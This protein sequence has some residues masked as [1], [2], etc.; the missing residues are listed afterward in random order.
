MP[1]IGDILKKIWCF[2]AL[3]GCIEAFGQPVSAADDKFSS[4]SFSLDFMTDHD[5]NGRLSVYKNQPTLAGMVGYYHKSGFDISTSY[6]NIWN[7]DERNES[8]T[9]SLGLSLGYNIDF[10][11]WLSGS[12]MYGHY[13]YSHDSH[14]LRS[15][16]KNLV[17][18][19][20][21]SEVG[22]WV[23]DVMAG[24]YTGKVEELF[25]AF[26][27]GATIHFDHVFKKGNSLSFQPM[28]SAY[29]GD[30]SY[31]NVEAYTSYL[32]AYQYAELFPEATTAELSERIVK[33]LVRLN[34]DN[35]SSQLTNQ[36][37]T[38]ITRLRKLKALPDDLVLWDLFK[39][40]KSFN[41]N[42]IG[43]TIPAYYYW[44]D[45]VISLG[46]SAFRPVNQPSYIEV[47]W[48]GYTNVGL[49]YFIS[50]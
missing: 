10:T 40:Q 28:V 22:W 7:S 17:S 35:T 20:L 6:S 49:T 37:K 47:N 25:V 42:N 16:Y 45:F 18:A 13:F 5:I 29:M 46:F 21:Y 24:Y 26:E 30:I 1:V 9:Q 4:A 14:S 50:W 36:Q 48:S 2:V 19:G 8:S 15:V 3:L 44:G 12:A 34:Q 39:E 41:F 38:L 11:E 27:T 43:F 31:Y 23:T 32:F 33:R